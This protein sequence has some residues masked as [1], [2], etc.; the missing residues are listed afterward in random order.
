M[1]TKSYFA[2]ALCFVMLLLVGSSIMAQ[3]KITGK[4]TNQADNQP[5]VGATVQ[6][7][8]TTNATQT[9]TDGS[10][11]I[12]AANNGTLV[13]TGVGYTSQEVSINGRSDISIAMQTTA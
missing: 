2:K 1:F 6:E 10:F 12:T 3:T 4:I 5:V 9:G 8:G 13:I 11:A 7:K